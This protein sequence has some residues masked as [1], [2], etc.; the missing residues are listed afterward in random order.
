MSRLGLVLIGTAFALYAGVVVW[1]GL[2][3]PGYSHLGQYISE[4]GAK[5]TVTGPAV[6]WAGFF[7][8]G[9]LMLAFV[10]VMAFSARLT[11]LR[12]LGLLLIAAYAWGMVNA[13][14]YRCDL[15]CPVVTDSL[16]QMMHN[17]VGALSYLLGVLG[18]FVLAIEARSRAAWVFG[19]GL[20]CGAVAACSFWLLTP[21]VAFKGLAQ[22]VLEAAMATLLIAW[23]WQQTRRVPAG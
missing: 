2:T 16:D 20:A 6:T 1:G 11:V 15:G 12:G 21:D 17:M 22:R 4:L 18:L 19:L 5:G 3:Y 8:P 23:T 10:G 14:I 9:V 13:V 7:I